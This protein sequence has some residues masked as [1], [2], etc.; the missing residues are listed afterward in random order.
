MLQSITQVEN[1]HITK[2]GVVS[3]QMTYLSRML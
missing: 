3:A 2:R 1:L